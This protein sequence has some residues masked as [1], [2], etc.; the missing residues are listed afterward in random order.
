MIIESHVHGRYIRVGE[1]TLEEVLPYIVTKE[2][3]LDLVKRK[4]KK[5]SHEFIMATERDYDGHMVKMTSQRYQ[6]F[7]SKGVVCVTCGVVGMY[8]ALEKNRNDQGNR[9]HFNLYGEKNGEEILFTKDHII[10]KSKGGRDFLS[11]YQ[12]MCVECNLE[13]ADKV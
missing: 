13:K 8:F 2:T 3:H 12:T 6:L 5:K 7:A 9:Y 11:N 1:Y 10:P 4:V